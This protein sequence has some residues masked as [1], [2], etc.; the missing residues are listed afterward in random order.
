MIYYTPEGSIPKLGLNFS[1]TLHGRIWFRIF[2]V[3]YDINTY[4]LT[5]YYFRFCLRNAPHFYADKTQGNVIEDY[6]FETNQ[7]LRL[8]NPFIIRS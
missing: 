3:W 1:S 7:K 5:S 4:T 2:W 6:L 8:E